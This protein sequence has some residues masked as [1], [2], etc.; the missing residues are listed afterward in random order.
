MRLENPLDKLVMSMEG[1][2]KLNGMNYDCIVY[3][4]CE[5]NLGVFASST[6]KKRQVETYNV[7]CDLIKNC[8]K[9]IMAS[10]FITDKTLNFARSLEL[11]I[12]LIR[13]TSLPPKRIANEVN[14]DLFNIKLY[15]SIKKGDKNYAVWCSLTAMKKFINELEGGSRENE[16]LLKVKENMLVYSSEVDDSQFDTL[17]EIETEWGNSSLVMT[18]PS[19]TVG[20]S[21]SPKDFTSVWVNGSPTCIVAQTFQGH[22][23]VRN[24]IENTMNFCLPMESM[25][26]FHKNTT[27][28][29]FTILAQYDFH[30]DEKRQLMVDL[31]KKLLK[32]KNE[33]NNQSLEIIE[34]SLTTEY[35]IT[36]EP[37]R[38]LLMFNLLE[39]ALS[40][41][42]YKEMFFQFL[43]MCNY[44]V[45]GISQKNCKVD[46][47]KATALFNNKVLNP[48]KYDEIE[49]IEQNE[50]EQ[51]KTLAEK[52]KATSI[53]K[54]QL[55]RY[56]FDQKIDLSL[57]LNV[58][59]NYFS[60]DEFSYN[61]GKMNNAYFEAKKT[62][63]DIENGLCDKI[64]N[65]NAEFGLHL[66]YAKL[67]YIREINEKLGIL[68]SSINDVIILRNKIEEIDEYLVTE[69]KLL[70]TLFNLTD[71]TVDKN[72][73]KFRILE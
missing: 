42:Y 35:Q 6:M 40:K 66:I 54:L 14:V 4:E 12:C 44:D 17:N 46:E 65:N 30:T 16:E 19:I 62:K 49:E 67:Q 37:L 73:K 34:R 60:L 5:D 70:H 61:K 1:L 32:N 2:H 71:K 56:Y 50:A 31:T 55:R 72:E 33:T 51:I 20:N 39:Q 68:S 21:Y 57:P 7:F 3:D 29:K 23:R 41:K 53:Q 11:P 69:R 38:Q 52:K 63:Q 64:K 18:T 59:K 13:N 48:I 36:P 43:K 47:S 25:L 15:E 26:R 10:A 9:L 27:E 28:I 24:L 8:K 45:K 22:M 58:I